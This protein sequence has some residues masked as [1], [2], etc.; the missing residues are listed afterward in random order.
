MKTVYEK[1]IIIIR[2]YT[3]TTRLMASGDG[4][5][6]VE[7]LGHKGNVQYTLGTLNE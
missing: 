4:N 6:L 7:D 3:F 1:P 5:A 2:Q